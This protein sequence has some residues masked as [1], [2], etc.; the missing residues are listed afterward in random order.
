[1]GKEAVGELRETVKTKIAEAIKKPIKKACNEFVAE[2]GHTGPGTKQKILKLF[3]DLA[4]QSTEAAQQP[5]TKILEGKF[6]VVRSEIRTVYEQWSD[7][8]EGAANVV[9][10]HNVEE[11]DKRTESEREEVL[12][13]IKQLLE[14][15]ESLASY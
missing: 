9:L 7:P 6:H 1:V 4:R 3:R 12:T 8:L 2:G 11:I 10:Q 14:A 15:R 13:T 5:A